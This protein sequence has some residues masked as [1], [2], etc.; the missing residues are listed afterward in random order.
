[1][2]VTG[3]GREGHRR[4]GLGWETQGKANLVSLNGIGTGPG[5]ARKGSAA[6]GPAGISKARLHV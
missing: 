3:R 4:E 1:M 6:I 5:G 2:V